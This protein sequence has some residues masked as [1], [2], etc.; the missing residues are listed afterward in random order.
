MTKEQIEKI[1]EKCP[2]EQGVFFQPYGIP[3]GVDEHVIYMRWDDS[4][5]SGGSCW[6]TSDPQPYKN[7]KPEFKVLDI[8]LEEIAPN[9]SYINYK[10]IE[11]LIQSNEYTTWEYYGNS[12]TYG[13]QYIKVAE[14]EELLKIF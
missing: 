8:V 11:S 10:K 6:D 12:T 9:I 3:I 1:N 7:D 2:Y 4:G 14:L 5:Y 13:I